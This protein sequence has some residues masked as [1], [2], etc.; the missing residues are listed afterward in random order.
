MQ[1]CSYGTHRVIV[2][3]GVLPQ[4]AWKLDATPHAYE[5]EILCDVEALNIDSASFRQID[6]ACGHDPQRIAEHIIDIVRTRGKQHNPVTGSGGVFIG[7]VL[8]IGA[9][10]QKSR[11]LRVGDRI[12]SLVS[13]SLTPLHIE[14][15]H[16]IDMTTGR[17]WIDGTAILFESGSYAKLPGDIPE[18]VAMPVLDV[19][20]AAAQVRKF[21]QPGQTVFIIGADGKSGLL[22]CV[23]AREKLGKSGLLIGV[24]PDSSTTAAHLL[25]NE[26]Y[27][28]ILVE[29]DARDALMLRDAVMRHAPQLADLTVNCVNVTGTEM[30]SILC[31]REEGMVYFFSTSTSFTGAMLGAEGVGKDVLMVIGNGYTKR[32]AELAFQTLRDHPAL[33]SYFL[34]RFGS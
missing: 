15:V 6:D 30:G 9:V 3:R 11:D 22:S 18:E 28:D 12:V 4:A 25:K 20:G 24:V 14:R 5:N 21:T 34:K 16:R 7:S 17:V 10:L 27:V 33:M 31:T 13:L 32:H 19:C 23:Q 26:R 8:E 1:P 29:A 2:P